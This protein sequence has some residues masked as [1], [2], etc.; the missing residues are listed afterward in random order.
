MIPFNELKTIH[1]FMLAIGIISTFSACHSDDSLIEKSNLNEERIDQENPPPSIKSLPVA[2]VTFLVGGEKF[3]SY[4]SPLVKGS[5][6]IN[7]LNQAEAYATG[8]IIFTQK[9]NLQ[10]SFKTERYNVTKVG[11]NLFSLSVEAGSNL[12]ETYKKLLDSDEL[13]YVEIEVKY[14]GLNQDQVPQ[15]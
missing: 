1:C 8:N 10:N 7:T 5:R 13:E 6:V 4:S 3:I 9:N 15:S 2:P 14:K 12:F 11:D